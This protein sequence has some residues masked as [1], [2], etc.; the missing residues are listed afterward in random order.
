MTV[1]YA[2]A[3]AVSAAVAEATDEGRILEVDER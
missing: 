3:A 1:S 2:A